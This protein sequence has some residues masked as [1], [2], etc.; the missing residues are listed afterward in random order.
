[1]VD[2]DLGDGFAPVWGEEEAEVV[3]V[4][5][6]QERGGTAQIPM[7]NCLAEISPLAF[8]KRILLLR[9]PGGEEDWS[10]NYKIGRIWDLWC[11]CDN[12]LKFG[13]TAIPFSPRKG[14]YNGVTSA[15]S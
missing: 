3:V 7:M 8:Q 11:A 13:A 10:W 15:V 2:L 9:E 5:C 6:V 1:V 12:K 14:T 4:V